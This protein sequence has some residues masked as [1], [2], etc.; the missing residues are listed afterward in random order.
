MAL[1][2]ILRAM[3]YKV[4]VF[5]PKDE[6]DIMTGYILNEE[7]I[8][9]IA[10]R[11][12]TKMNQD[13][14]WEIVRVARGD[15][16]TQKLQTWLRSLNILSID[17]DTARKIIMIMDL[18]PDKDPQVIVTKYGYVNFRNSPWKLEH[19]VTNIRMFDPDMDKLSSEIEKQIRNDAGI[20]PVHVT[21]ADRKLLEAQNEFTSLGG[22][23]MHTWR[24]IY[25]FWGYIDADRLRLLAKKDCIG[26]IEYHHTNY[27]L[28][29]R[30]SI[31]QL[32]VGTNPNKLGNSS[33]V[34]NS[35]TPWGKGIYGDPYT[36]LV[37]VDTGID[38]THPE[39]SPYQDQGF[40][41]AKIVYWRDI[42]GA[43]PG[44][45]GDGHGHGSHCSGIAAGQGNPSDP[46]GP[47]AHMGV[48]PNVSLGG[49]K[50]FSDSGWFVD[51]NFQFADYLLNNRT[52][53]HIVV[54]SHSWG[55]P[56][57]AVLNELMNNLVYNGIVQVVAAGN[58]GSNA[59]IGSPGSADLVI[60]VGAIN[61]LNEMAWYSTS[62]DTTTGNTIKPDVTAN[63]GSGFVNETFCSDDEDGDEYIGMVGSVDSNDADNNPG[64]N[65]YV[66]WCGT[67]MATP[68]VSGLAALVIDAL[69]GW[70]SWDFSV[71]MA[72]K[73][74][75]II[76]MT[77]TEFTREEPPYPGYSPQLTPTLDR[78]GKDNVEGYGRIN[79]DAAVL[80]VTN[81]LQLNTSYT[82]TLGSSN[83]EAWAQTIAPRAWAGNIYLQ[84]GDKYR[85]TLD[86]P[87]GADFDLYVYS[88]KPDQYGQPVLIQS[89]VNSTPGG[90]EVVEFVAD[91][92]GKYYIVVKWIDRI[93]TIPDE[94]N[95]GTFN[96]TIT[97]LGKGIPIVKIVN[98]HTDSW[99]KGI[100]RVEVNATDVDGSIASVS[101]KIW[102]SSWSTTIDITSNYNATRGL[103][104]YDWNTS[105]VANGKYSI[106]AIAVDNDSKESNDTI[107]IRVW[108][109]FP[110][111]VLVDDDKGMSYETYYINSLNSLG[112][113]EGKDYLVWSIQQNGTPNNFVLDNTVIIVWFTGNDYT[114]TLTEDERQALTRFLSRLGQLFISGRDIGFDIG[115][116]DWYGS[117]LKAEYELD[118]VGIRNV[119]GV[120][121]TIF[122]GAFYLL[123]G[124]DSANNSHW[125]DEISPYNGSY[126]VMYY[127]SNPDNGSAIAYDD[128]Y[129]LVYFAFPFE[130]INGSA[131]RDDAINRILEWMK[132]PICRI[133]SY[134]D[135]FEDSKEYL[136]LSLMA[137]AYYYVQRAEIYI[138]GSLVYNETPHEE[139]IY[140]RNLTLN[141]TSFPQ[142]TLNVTFVVTDNNGNYSS[143]TILLIP[144]I[145]VSIL[146]PEDYDVEWGNTTIWVN[147]SS[148]RLPL[149]VI[150]LTISNTTWSF[151]ENIITNYD[152]SRGLY[153]YNWCTTNFMDGAYNITIYAESGA[154]SDS[155]T[156]I[157]VGVW[158]GIIP[159][160]L[161]DGDHGRQYETYYMDSLEALGYRRN[162]EYVYW[163][164]N[165]DGTPPTGFVNRAL[166]MIW[167]CGLSRPYTSERS[168][169]SGYLENLG[170]LFI[171][172]QDIGYYLGDTTWYERWLKAKYE[173]DDTDI[174]N[175][176]GVVSTLFDGAFYLLSGS[177]SANNNIWP[178]EISP[179]NGSYLV[180]YYGSNPDNGSAIAYDNEYRLVYFAF[181]FEAI[182]GSSNRADAM[183][184]I[185][186]W[187]G[188]P[189]GFI[190]SPTNNTITNLD[191]INISIL[192]KAF[193]TITN[194]K[195]FVNGSMVVNEGANNRVLAKNYTID[196]SLYPDYTTLNITLYVED[197]LGD[198]DTYTIYVIR[199]RVPPT[200]TIFTPQNN[201]YHNITDITVSWS[202]SDNLGVDHYEVQQDGSGWLNVGTSTSYTFS[203]LNEGQHTIEIKAV[204]LAGNTFIMRL[205]I[206]I[207]LTSPVFISVMPT[208][209]S[210]VQSKV[211]FTWNFTDNYGIDHYAIKVDSGSWI[212]T[213]ANSYTL[214]YL[215][216]GT[217]WVYIKAYDFA[218]N[219]ASIKVKICVDTT[220]PTV[221][222]LT[223]LGGSYLNTSD[224]N[225]TWS[226]DDNYGIDYCEIRIDGGTWINVGN[227][228][229]YVV[230]GLSEG[231]HFI[232]VRVYDLAGN[233]A[234]DTIMI[235]I[236]LTDPIIVA[237]Y[238][239]SEVYINTTSINISWDAIDNTGIDKYYVSVGGTS[240]IDIGSDNTYM[241]TGLAEGE[242]VLYI[243]AV[244][245][246]GNSDVATVTVIVDLE[247]PVVNII[248]PYNGTYLSTD[249]VIISWE[250]SDNLGIDRYEIS[251]NGGP[252]IDLGKSTGYSLVNM[253]EQTYIIV[254]RCIDIAGNIGK[255]I[256]MFTT[257]YTSPMFVEYSP[258]DN[259]YFNYTDLVITWNATDNIGIE[260]YGV[261][262]DGAVEY[263]G[264]N[265]SL[266]ISLADGTHTIIIRAYDK[267]GNAGEVRISIHID[268]Q[269]PTV[270]IVYPEMD[271]YINSERIEVEWSATD[272]YGIDHY[273]IKMDNY[274]WVST[275]NTKYV[276]DG[277]GSGVHTIYVRVYDYAGNMDEAEVVFIVDLEPPTIKI[278]EPKNNSVLNETK[279]II[280]WN[281]TDDMALDR[282][283]ISINGSKWQDLGL[284]RS[285]EL[286]LNYGNY[287]ILFRVYD[288]A[289]NMRE[290]ALM[291]RI[292][293]IEAP[294]AYLKW[295]PLII[296]GAVLAIAFVI[297]P[298][299]KKRRA[300]TE[301]ELFETPVD[302]VEEE[303]SSE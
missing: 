207:D 253:S 263:S 241:F 191:T 54:A 41:A 130:A 136:N 91:R 160:L 14:F 221:D 56:D 121:G 151:T 40:G 179:Y 1:A 115:H 233:Y 251:I 186:N 286:D 261:E 277:V 141:L 10:S 155:D 68:H 2:K 222:I 109:N 180:M 267:A 281:V 122:N 297:F 279:V 30:V 13:I 254:V 83:P 150:N 89:G 84:A 223:P 201:S 293:M 205:I 76:L 65:N 73:V 301:E 29:L 80:A 42:S 257:D 20:I 116:T 256:L 243:K 278:L 123:Y 247:P 280:S 12:E 295:L 232:E 69:G 262:I 124:S 59:N 154:Y 204:D 55:G 70:E 268:L 119:T 290:V 7:M 146:Y 182:N 90:D 202:G 174:D 143:H 175:V 225:V 75:M 129:R 38:D 149:T 208:N 111:I 219:S 52:T 77:A 193:C 173:L 133:L 117:W 227:A 212:T 192:A 67:S 107:D 15:K 64:S 206:Y 215:T 226:M 248:Y 170:L 92:T 18:L 265:N 270:Y 16:P 187:L 93:G 5:E 217:H 285:I 102:N 17:K 74:K 176:T 153:Y 245:K 26:F 43:Y 195:I 185:I 287:T 210:Y 53:Y 137:R 66:D 147:V 209:D 100:V 198:N 132:R 302:E 161:I 110:P 255:D 96:L 291:F 259:S 194:V 85:I 230:T 99:V 190:R 61:D 216:E 283:E 103:Y 108:N 171:S 292:K 22:K 158:N 260:Y 239:A 97:R 47:N 166:I 28:Y 87:D 35:S 138:N 125:L 167:L 58:D 113:V 273:E 264:T 44:S 60:T 229:S 24:N 271:A 165:E 157:N 272:N 266:A 127:G 184:R 36:T 214:E 104:Y 284:A 27:S 213:S 81:T 23:I 135:Y 159:I 220:D 231:T 244:D 152:R 19:W 218:E 234:T 114:T 169:I 246:A 242:S 51:P 8:K 25:A 63:G 94:N 224:V 86:V 178:D 50:I 120:S 211:T 237:I 21:A 11:L 31:P 228:N 183:Q 105:E 37:I 72:L 134:S 236:D 156:V 303:Q 249:N 128:E 112:Y 106:M 177:D 235:N 299:W 118:D 289:G 300:R 258:E 275:P 33:Y 197:S 276:F 282:I 148:V 88:G 131:N 189:I 49:I 82:Y 79:A 145:S 78:G 4:E 199:D 98:P 288:K 45:P 9:I 298:W 126:L 140:S 48:A 181:P 71:D 203:G 62:G 95:T 196:V 142:D 163:D 46:Y 144:S 39:L 6:K 34:Y 240:W 188:R 294:P 274:S 269:A 3:N 200:L 250:G 101:L 238:P 168:I 252:W 164:L 57:D 32:R 139:R 172:G 162:F 296:I